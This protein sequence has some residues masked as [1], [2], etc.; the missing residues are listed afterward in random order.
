M[1]ISLSLYS[2]FKISTRCCIPT[3]I[4]SIIASGST[5]KPYCFESSMTLSLASFFCKKPILLG[6]TPKMIFSKTVKISTSL[7]CWWTIP[8]PSAFASFGLLI[9]TLSPFFRIS[10]FSGWYKPKRTLI[11]VDFPAPFSPRSA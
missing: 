6:S 4:F 2:I 8:I 9:S 11:K 5:C 3:D 1:R 7:K 10:P